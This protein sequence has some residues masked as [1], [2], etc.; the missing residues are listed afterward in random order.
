MKNYLFSI[1]F[2]FISMNLMS[3]EMMVV[4]NPQL[5]QNILYQDIEN[6]WYIPGIKKYKFSISADRPCKIEKSVYEQSGIRYDCFKISNVPS[7]NYLTITL[8][9]QGKSYG[10]FKFKVMPKAPTV[11]N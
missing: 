9:G 2:L 1:A 3:Q 7:C 5:N 4:V 8:T 11:N 10:Q 6:I